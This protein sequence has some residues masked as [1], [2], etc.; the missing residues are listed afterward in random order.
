M[1][2][3]SRL[4]VAITACAAAGAMTLTGCGSSGGSTGAGTGSIPAG[5]G[6]T[7]AG[8]ATGS[9]ASGQSAAD[10]VPAA[11][12]SKGTLVIASDASYPPMEFFKPG[13]KSPVIGMDADLGAALG[14]ALGLNV[15]IRNVTFDAIIPGLADG[16]YDIGL[17]SFTDTKEREKTV[18]FVTYYN[19]GES[20]YI[21]SDNSKSYNGLDSLCG[22]KVAVENGTTE[23]SDAQSQ[24]KKCAAEGKPKVDVLQFAD[25]SGANLAVANGRADVGFADSP[26][27]DYIVQSSNGQ[28]KN[29]GQPFGL[30]PYGIAL[31]KGN[32]M[33][34][35]VQAA[36]EQLISDGS[37]ASMLKKWNL[38]EGAITAPEING[39]KS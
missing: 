15:E 38:A 4:L 39:A 29:T 35:A 18:D 26:P 14:K 23:Q 17:S 20:F 34:K 16:K 30:A 8:A 37:Y 7:P 33:A 2:A 6:S 9:S 36:L 3:R 22:A 32:G 19:A 11:V 10:L 24:S 27:V 28:F 25:Q 5:A 12:K 13:T 31:P 1:F 21:K